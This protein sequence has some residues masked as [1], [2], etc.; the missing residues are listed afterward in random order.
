MISRFFIDRPIFA[1]VLSIVITLTGV[2]ALRSL[3]MAQYPRITPPGVSV[4]IAYPGASAQVVS[5]TVAAPIEQQVNGVPGMLYMSSQCGNDGSYTLTVTF[6]LD[7]DLNTALVLV[8]NRVTLAMPQLPNSVQMQGIT[9]KKKTPDILLVVNFYSPDGRYDDIYLSNY[10]Y[11][12]VRDELFRVEGVSDINILG[13]RDYSIRAWLDPQKLASCN[14]T[15]LEVAAAIRS[16]NIEAPAGQFGQPPTERGQSLQIPLDTLGRLSDPE[17]FGDIII[18]V[19]L[20][21]QFVS[22]QPAPYVPTAPPPGSSTTNGGTQPGNSLSSGSLSLTMNSG[23]RTNT[24]SPTVSTT[25]SSPTSGN[26]SSSS[27]PGIATTSRQDATTASTTANNAALGRGL[28]TPP[29]GGMSS[30]V[31]SS[32]TTSG[33]PG[34]TTPGIGYGPPRGVTSSIVRL[35][36]VA[37]VEMA[38]KNYNQASTFDGKPSVGLA[39]YQ[40]PGTNA[41]D[42]ADA[43]RARMKE[44]KERFPDG[45][46]YD[47]AYDITPFVRESITDVVRTLLEAVVL[48]AV[49]VL[50]FLQN[51]RAALI[52][53]LAVPV[54]IIGTFAVMAALG[55]SL[56]NI[57]LFGLVLAIGIVVD[58]AIVVVENVERWLEHGHPPREA[59][60]KAMDEVTGPVIA[61]ALVLCA[62]FVPCAFISGITGQFFRQFAVTIAVSTVISA[63]N[64]LTLSPALAA[65]L[66]K[67]R[68]GRRD[69]LT[70]FLDV[71]LGWLFWLFNAT[72]RAGTAAYAWSVGHLLRVSIVVLTVYGGLLGLTYWVFQHAPTGFIPQQDQGRLI[73]NVELPDSAS[74]QRT[75]E[76]VALVEQITRETKGVAHTV[77]VS[78]MSFLLSANSSNFGSLFV[79]LDPFDQ[80]T[81]PNLRDT[82]IMARLR[83]EW[84]KRVKDARV[85]VFGAPPI[86]G[87]SVAGGFKLMVEDRGAL[88]LPN[89]QEQ[90]EKLIGNGPP[91]PS[92]MRADRALLGVNTQFRSNTPQL[93]MDIDRTKVESLGVSLDDVNQTLQMYLGSLYVNSF[94]IFGR[95]WQVTIQAEGQYRSHVEDINLLEVRNKK[96]QMV[97]LGTLVHV[98]G[99]SGPVMVTRYNLY[100]SAA[101]TGM[102][103]PA[104]SSGPVIASIDEL[105]R[106]TLP[107]SMKAEWTELMFMQIRAGNTAMYVFALAVVFVFLALAALYE[108]WAMPLAVILVVPLCLL[109]S[110]AGVLLSH[111]PVDIFVQIGLVVLVG[112]ACKNS[113]LIVEFA[114]QLRHQ[115][116]S[117][118]DATVEA[119]RL[120]LRPILMTSFAFILG[121]LPLVIAHGAGAEMRRSLGTAVF[122]GMLG[123]TLFG[124][125][126]TPVF[127]Y[128]IAWLGE[129]RFLTNLTTRWVGSALAGGL[130]GSA[131]GYWLAKL[132]VG[133]L[134]QA[135]LAGFAIG[136]VLALLIPAIGRRI[137]GATGG[138]PPAATP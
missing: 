26:T 136:V 77:T 102:I 72:F 45:V 64:S 100:P 15:P 122:A 94:N 103:H 30:S 19:G 81:T 21:G 16:Q 50:L 58:D 6:D 111:K 23:N 31:S 20:G 124:I 54:A 36:D 106:Q 39:V 8:Q 88:G 105:S 66:L 41:L 133:R 32:G 82:A 123:V 131:V 44:L 104:V 70:L 79:I 107:R 35:R 85:T 95:Y 83:R 17:Q 108:S 47:I 73:V 55:F 42:V 87:L 71:T 14:M 89:L 121:V 24:T 68:G 22:S 127:F 12:N 134:P 74:L 33:L 101:I 78:G 75:Q 46:D 13:E 132:G 130:L 138:R 9:I 59:A 60:R 49:V 62:V 29:S 37:R 2:I 116:R 69:P 92:G 135:P 117:R 109:C 25:S 97:P 3:P 93:Y 4:S 7:T 128:V 112:L 115:G 76:A 137:R 119:C 90:T 114:Q 61:V 48:V 129:T 110:V 11:I 91:N 51:W 10:A 56:N 99:V 84:S 43:V 126:L 28:Q 34:G 38:A 5:D 65:I 40:L 57:S 86:P 80:R 96:G 27:T 120:R 98:R 52:P 67:P 53:L 63:F 118:F 18:K 113:I 1:T 125:L